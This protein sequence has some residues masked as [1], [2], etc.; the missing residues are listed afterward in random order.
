MSR[1]LLDINALLA[2]LDPM[3]VHHDNA[4][5]WYEANSP[6]QLLICPHVE[7]GVMRVASQ[8]RYP[9]H[10]GTTAMVRENLRKF[11]EQLKVERCANDASLLD[12]N[13]LKK[14]ALLTTSSIADLYL[15]AVAVANNAKLATFDR[16]INS[17]AIQ[18]E[19]KALVVIP[20][21]AG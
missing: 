5:R 4:H 20:I 3:H 1:M 9:N 10:L 17:A 21:Q 14:P 2:L 7:N 6:V 8:P 12:D 13:I 15:L 11:T 18:G 19:K 16:R